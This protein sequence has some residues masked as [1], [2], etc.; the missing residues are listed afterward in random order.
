[1]VSGQK[2]IK[3]SHSLN[4]MRA[5]IP[6][7][8]VSTVQCFPFTSI[9]FALGNPIIDFFSLDVEG[10][11]LEILKTVN[12]D[13]IRIRVLLVEVAH[14]SKEEIKQFLK[15]KGFKF[16]RDIKNQD[17]V[18]MNDKLEGSILK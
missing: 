4:Q 18:F 12:F 14:G 13:L 11:E 6:S 9:V 7:K 15:T 8:H 2:D 3:A 5:K 17:F 16:I 1:M 10:A